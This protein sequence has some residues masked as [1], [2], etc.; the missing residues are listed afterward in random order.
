MKFLKPKNWELV[1]NIE[2]SNNEYNSSQAW[3]LELSN[4]Y[5]IRRNQN[6]KRN[7]T[8]QSFVNG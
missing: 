4:I 7:W 8:K 3:K 1:V 6:T 2:K 5:T